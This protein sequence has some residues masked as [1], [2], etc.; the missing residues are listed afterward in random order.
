MKLSLNYNFSWD[1]KKNKKT[2]PIALSYILKM[3]TKLFKLIET[4]ESGDVHYD[5]CEKYLNLKN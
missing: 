4:R 5:H 1:C 3:E 2:K